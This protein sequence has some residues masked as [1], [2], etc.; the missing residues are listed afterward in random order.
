MRT[1]VVQ[2]FYLYP[3][4]EKSASGKSFDF[5]LINRVLKY[6]RPYKFRFRLTLFLTVLLALLGPVRP[7]LI[8]YTVDHFIVVPHLQQLTLFC[9][10]L[11]GV[12]GIETIIQYYQ[13]YFSGFM[14][15]QVVKDIRQQLYVHISRFKLKFYDRTPIGTLVTRV[16]N[17]VETI[18][19]VFSEGLLSI[20]GD[21]LKLLVIFGFMFYRD[22]ELSIACILP[23]PILLVATNIFRRGIGKT[24]NE[25]RNQVANMNAFTQEHITGM[26]MIQAFNREEIE[27]EKFRKINSKH[28]KAHIKSV[29]Y[30]SIFFPVVE[31]LSALSV[32]LMVFW[33][34]R[35]IIVNAVSHSTPGLIIEFILYINM[36]YR[37]MR[38]L[39][40][41]FN[42][43]QM[44][45][46]SSERIFKI[47][48]TDE[49][50]KDEGKITAE[51]I[52]GNIEMKNVYFSYVENEPIL[53]NFNL[54]IR[55]GEK[56]AI[57]GS[58]GS[59]KTTITNLISRMYEV[60]SG[61]ILFD[62]IDIKAYQLSELQKSI[63]IVLQDVFLF[64]DTV[65]NNVTL[66]N[67]EISETQVIAAAKAVGAHDF[68]M[69]LPG[70]YNYQIGERGAQLSVGQRQLLSFIRAYVYDPKVL[71]L[72]EATSSIDTESEWMIQT[73]T[74]KITE[75]RTSI[76][77]AHR[78][79]TIKNATRILV[80]EKGKI[81]EMGSHLELM[82]KNGAYKK[83][84]ELQ[85]HGV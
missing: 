30:Y 3:V 36:M 26:H 42:T 23:V 67:K 31:I 15:H 14:G 4:A 50:L 18:A 35:D 82:M 1:Y 57:V 29:W 32:S 70:G 83:L 28:R 12:L 8:S 74:E 78:L 25:V 24:F 51:H 53:E 66:R 84:F 52:H 59:G 11:L 13:T 81:V 60:N 65:T 72:D 58:T 71:I 77:I 19:D 80:M 37:P 44:G 16:I 2:K 43:L 54:S 27:M 69:K 73:A 38:Q 21:V 33:A 20:L 9:L 40:D 10:I 47:I 41:R 5:A 49:S 56:I 17:D 62:G 79:S 39:A 48:D 6:T 68:I 45:V 34:A 85:F 22:W 55:E 46:V 63:G 61:E 75:G 64:D 76:I 7:F